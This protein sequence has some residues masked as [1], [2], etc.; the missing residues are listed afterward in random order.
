MNFSGKYNDKD[1]F[2]KIENLPSDKFDGQIVISLFCDY[3]CNRKDY[4]LIKLNDKFI[5]KCQECGIERKTSKDELM[6]YF[7]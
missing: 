6:K 7:L 2:L 4:N 5:F 3:C 1:L